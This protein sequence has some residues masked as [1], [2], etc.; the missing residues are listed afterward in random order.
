[1]LLRYS[2]FFRSLCCQQSVSQLKQFYRKKQITT[3]EEIFVEKFVEKHY[4][5]FNTDVIEME[6]EDKFVPSHFMTVTCY[7]KKVHRNE[8]KYERYG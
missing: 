2:Y 5:K 6:T 8:V 4:N 7:H 3:D 1:M